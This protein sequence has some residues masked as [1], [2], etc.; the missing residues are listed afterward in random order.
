MTATPDITL[1]EAGPLSA[2]FS[3]G[4]LRNILWHGREAIRAISYLVRDENWGNYPIEISN[5]TQSRTVKAFRLS[6][7]AVARSNSSAELLVKVTIEGHADGHL[8]FDAVARPDADFITNR[9]GFCVLHPIVGVS[10]SPVTVEHVDGSIEDARFPDEI[11]PA[12]PFFDM[13]SITHTVAPGV[14]AECRMEGGIFEMEDQ[15]NWTDASYK[16]YVRPLA[17]PWPYTISGGETDHQTI[18]LSLKG[19][20]LDAGAQKAGGPVKLTIGAPT[21]RMFEFGLG[22]RPADLAETMRHVDKLSEIAPKHLILYFSPLEGHGGQELRDY[23]ALLDACPAAATLEFVLPCRDTPKEELAVLAMDVEAAG[24]KLAA[25]AVSPAP[26][27]KSTPPGSKWPE[28]PPLA[29]IYRAARVAFPGLRLGGGMFSY[30]TE[31]NRKRPPVEQLDF[32]T[33]T[34][35][36]LVH[37]ADDRSVMETLEALPFI[38]RSVRAFAGDMPYRIGPSSM[39]YRIGPSSIGMRHNPYGAGLNPNPDGIRM[40][41]VADDPRQ[42]QQFAAAW[43]IG[44]AAA[45]L[46]AGLEVL[47]LGSLCGPFGVIGEGGPLP[48]YDAARALARLSGTV[49]RPVASSDPSRVLAL[50]GG[51]TLLIAN[52]TPEPVEIAVGDER[53]RLGPYGIRPVNIGAT[54]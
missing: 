39:P 29:D 6:Y 37:A 24:L 20:P 53:V 2:E 7:D 32:I 41:M 34:T 13:R 11:D 5:L 3:G 9:C 30:F 28:C 18:L 48:A 12:Q 17:W 33:H 14:T 15:R 38:T 42:K 19:A 36:P 49:S 25:L 52:L 51:D 47:A 21:R 22:V 46:E 54:G 1:L 40:T 4:N 27:L 31:L 50:A 44:Y 8:T 45:T 43:M 35:A 16:T 26:D 10:G 23:A